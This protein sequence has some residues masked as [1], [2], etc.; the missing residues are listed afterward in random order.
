MENKLRDLASGD[1]KG[2]SL[3]HLVGSEKQ[4]KQM[5]VPILEATVSPTTSIL[6]QID[7]GFYDEAPW[8]Q[9]Q[10]VKGKRTFPNLA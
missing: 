4:K 6:W 8:T 5:K 2:K 3:S 7:V 10:I 9:Q 1:W